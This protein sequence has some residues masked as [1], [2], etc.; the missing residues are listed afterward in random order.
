MWDYL[1]YKIS[2]HQNHDKSSRKIV[3]FAAANI[4]LKTKKAPLTNLLSAVLCT[5]SCFSTKFLLPDC[6]GNPRVGGDTLSSYVVEHTFLMHPTASRMA[7]KIRL[8][9]Q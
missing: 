6:F 2:P 4:V 1:H 5:I 8:P 3:G 7:Q 9:P